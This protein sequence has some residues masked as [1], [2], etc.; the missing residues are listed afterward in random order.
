MKLQEIY[1]KALKVADVV[2]ASYNSKY[3]SKEVIIELDGSICVEYTMWVLGG[4]SE[5]ETIYISES[6]L[7]SLSTDEIIVIR[8]KEIQDYN[9]KIRE[10]LILR[11]E[12]E[13]LAKEKSE[14][15]LYE[16]LKLKFG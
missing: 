16:E 11:H 1:N 12:E 10:K 8:L 4:E 5:S 13:L 9:E 6:E 7:E 3:T 15:K 14:R 2:L